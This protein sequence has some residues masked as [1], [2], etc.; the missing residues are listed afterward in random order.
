MIVHGKFEVMIATNIFELDSHVNESRWED[1][2]KDKTGRWITGYKNTLGRTG[3]TLDA[4]NS[5]QIWLHVQ[6]SEI[7]IPDF[8]GKMHTSYTSLYHKTLPCAKRDIY[9]KTQSNPTI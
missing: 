9:P 2:R 4:L 3:A 7:K 8:P 6:C 5:Q 1:L